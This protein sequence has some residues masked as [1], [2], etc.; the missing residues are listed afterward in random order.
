MKKILYLIA[1]ISTF[2]FAQQNN[3]KPTAEVKSNTEVGISSYNDLL[4]LEPRYYFYPNLEAY[5]DMQK[6]KFIL[7]QDGQWAE[8][9][10]VPNGYR[11]YSLYNS[12][13]YEIDDYYGSKPY[14]YLAKHKEQFPTK[15]SA[16]TRTVVSN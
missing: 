3:E 6:E 1:L 9:A 15:Y 14:N 5:Y 8:V 12:V 7:K 10:E 2:S 11:G 4:N 16:R 13:N